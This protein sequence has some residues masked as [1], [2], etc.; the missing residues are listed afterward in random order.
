MDVRKDFS[1]N[2]SK[3]KEK[4]NAENT[5]RKLLRIQYP[6]LY[7]H[8]VE[9]LSIH[10]IHPFDITASC[11][12]VADEVEI[13]IAFGEGFSRRESQT[14][15]KENLD[16]LDPAFTSFCEKVGEVCKETM[17]SDYFNIVNP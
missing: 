8:L 1:E 15:P 16:K 12:E 9:E 3:K 13:E 17:I 2:L 14:F 5:N 6:K 7:E 4:K 10:H 11:R